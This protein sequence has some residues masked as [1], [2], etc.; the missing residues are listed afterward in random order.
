MSL[1]LLVVATQ[2]TPPHCLFQF[3]LYVWVVNMNDSLDLSLSHIIIMKKPLYSLQVL[4]LWDKAIL[5][6][7][8]TET[9]FQLSSFIHKFRAPLFVGVVSFTLKQQTGLI[10][11]KKYSKRDV[12]NPPSLL[13]LSPL[14]VFTCIYSV[15]YFL[16]VL[17]HSRS[18]II[19]NKIRLSLIII[20]CYC[21]LLL[22]ATHRQNS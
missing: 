13:F 10:I 21:P 12:F 7:I 1:L 17:K 9:L 4:M 14:V 8:D 19:I 3:H 5:Y 20:I 6:W 11:W 15:Y 16:H 18:P 22:I 2:Y